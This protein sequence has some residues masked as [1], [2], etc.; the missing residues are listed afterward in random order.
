MTGPT[1]AC[2]ATDDELEEDD[3]LI[4]LPDT[5]RAKSRAPRL[6]AELRRR[7][8]A[9][10]LV[11]VDTSADSIFRPDSV[12]IAHIFRAKGNEAPMVYAIDSQNAATQVNA[13]SRRN[14]L[15]T[16]ITRSR[17]WV[18]ITGW[19]ERLDP[20]QA[21][22]DQILSQNFQLN[23]TIPTEAELRTMRHVHRE[24]AADE[25]A[26][27]LRATE[28]LSMF[29]E[30]LDAGEIDLEDLPPAIRTRLAST[31]LTDENGDDG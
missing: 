9:S 28:G 3:I 21:E 2:Q 22:L 10:H 30:A 19:G 14:I 6:K 11:G 29:L 7:K 8:I 4:V 15:F 18:R 13:V 1:G 26:S 23:F 31:L 5:Y 24:R 27:I 16:A 20:I 25:E 17:A 12:A